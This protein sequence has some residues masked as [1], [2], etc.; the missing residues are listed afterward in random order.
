M[1]TYMMRRV[2][3]LVVTLLAALPIPTGAALAAEPVGTTVHEIVAN[4]TDYYGQTILLTGAVEE[5]LG[6][7]SFTLEDDDLLYNDTLPVVSTRPVLTDTGEPVDM[8]EVD[9]YNVLVTGT[10]RSFDLAAIERD[11]D[12]DLD[13]E[14]LAAW[15]GTPVIVARSVVEWSPGFG[16]LATRPAG[17]QEVV[18]ATVDQITDQ[19]SAFYADIVVVTGELDRSIGWRSFVIEDNDLLFDEELLVVSARPL[20]DRDGQPIRIATFALQQVPARVTGNVRPFDLAEIERELDLDLDDNLYTEWVGKPV[21][22]AT[23]V[24][25]PRVS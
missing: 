1:N 10:V 25:L 4:P 11:L 22:I 13:D 5:A 2:A 16:P 8:R 18:E 19:P 7:R 17:A 3:I 23:S 20:V 24:R 14:Q 9:A 12:F 21:L 6:P 15:A